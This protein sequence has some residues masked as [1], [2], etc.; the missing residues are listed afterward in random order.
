MTEGLDTIIKRPFE[1]DNSEYPFKDNGYLIVMGI[2]IILMREKDL[3]FCF[4]T[5]IQRGRIFTEISSR[6]CEENAA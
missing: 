5:E 2:F 6:N 3:L 4:F 1:V